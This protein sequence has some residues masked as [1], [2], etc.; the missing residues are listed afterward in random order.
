LL[1][2]AFIK[3][4]R[5]KL[6]SPHGLL[7]DVS[8]VIRHHIHTHLILFFNNLSISLMQEQQ[9][10]QYHYHHIGGGASLCS[11]A[12]HLIVPGFC[13]CNYYVE[14]GVTRL[15]YRAAPRPDQC[16]S[17]RRNIKARRASL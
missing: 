1:L 16:Q 9:Q 2:V 10:Q 17:V 6:D 7:P 15:G 13:A 5:E 3:E 11:A 4:R 8:N 12:V 14:T